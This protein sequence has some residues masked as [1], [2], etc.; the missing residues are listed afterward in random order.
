MIF[1]ISIVIIM[2]VSF[3]WALASLRFELKKKKHAHMKTSHPGPKHTKP[4]EV[5][6]FENIR[7][8]KQKS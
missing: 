5:V 1:W 2:I 7:L 4:K 8:K 6:L 3:L